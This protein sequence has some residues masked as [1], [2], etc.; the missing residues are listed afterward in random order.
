VTGDDR[1]SDADAH[2]TRRVADRAVN[3]LSTSC[4]HPD[5]KYP[6]AAGSFSASPGVS[7]DTLRSILWDNVPTLYGKH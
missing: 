6:H 1:V 3:Q 2:A 5:S 7:D 4:P